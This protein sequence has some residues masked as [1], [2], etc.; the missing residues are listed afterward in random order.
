MD[1]HIYA[2]TSY[3]NTKDVIK[4]WVKEPSK[5]Y[6]TPNNTYKN[7]SLRKMFQYFIILC[8]WIYGQRRIETF[9]EGWVYLLH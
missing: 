9:L 2:I 4:T 1:S 6:Q 8:C 3:L 5:F 7:K